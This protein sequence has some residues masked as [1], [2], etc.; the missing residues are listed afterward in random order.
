LALTWI[1]VQVEGAGGAP[2][3]LADSCSCPAFPKI[4][5]GAASKH[6][7]SSVTGSVPDGTV[8]GIRLPFGVGILDEGHPERLR[9]RVQPGLMSRVGTDL[10]I[11]PKDSARIAGTLEGAPAGRTRIRI[12]GGGREPTQ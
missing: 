9:V 3:V 11:A 8:T 4:A 6:P 12:V 2:K 5:D 10:K 7:V 1:G